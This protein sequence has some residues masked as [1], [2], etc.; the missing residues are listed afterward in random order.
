V[1]PFVTRLYVQ[2]FNVWVTALLGVALAAA[3]MSLGASPRLGLLLGL[4]LGLTTMQWIYARTFFAEPLTALLTL[5]SFLGITR[6]GQTGRARWLVLSGLAAGA[7]LLVKPHM[8]AAWPGL[9]LYLMLMLGWPEQRWQWPGGAWLR[10][11]GGPLARG[12]LLWGGGWLPPVLLML[13]YNALVYGHPLVFGNTA[14]GPVDWNAPLHVALYGITL[15][16]GKGIIFYA[17]LAVAGLVA[18]YEMRRTHRWAAWSIW[19]LL[20]LNW[21]V[22]HRYGVWWGGGSWGPRYVLLVLPFLLLPLAPWLQAARG[23]RPRWAGIAALALAGLLVQGIGAWTNFATV[24]QG[25]DQTERLWEPAASP[26]LLQARLAAERWQIW[27]NLLR[28]PAGS[29]LVLAGYSYEG[30]EESRR[31]GIVPLRALPELVLR[32]QP[33]DEQPLTLRLATEAGVTVALHLDGQALTP[34]AREQPTA[35]T[36]QVTWTLPGGGRQEPRLLIRPA[37]GR[38]EATLPLVTGLEVQQGERRLTLLAAPYIPPMPSARGVGM[39]ATWR[40]QSQWSV[41]W[42]MLGTWNHC[43]R[44]RGALG[45]GGM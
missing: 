19:L 27:Q 44:R 15:S 41:R 3:A 7:G 24:I 35:A 45:M 32:V 6:H 12:L 28:Q 26:I 10:A 36:Q 22:V 43:Q 18:L 37:P 30:L 23:N 34:A 40:Y 29:V 13:L 42:G 2:T 20:L 16:A 5:L 21:L 17:P 11:R 38:A 25:D 31:Q 33:V 39:P 14:G 8:L 4:L 1:Q 9:G